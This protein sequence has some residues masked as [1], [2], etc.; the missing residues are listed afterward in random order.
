M[1]ILFF[2]D[3]T[4]KNGH[5]RYQTKFLHMKHLHTYRRFISILAQL[6]A[7]NEIA[8][9]TSLTKSSMRTAK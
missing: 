9:K 8:S 3:Y 7:V 2:D 4:R 6:K 5:Y 1:M